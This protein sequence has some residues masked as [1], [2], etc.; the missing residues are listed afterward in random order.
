MGLSCLKPWTGLII[1]PYD[2]AS[3]D[4]AI[5]IFADVI[6]VEATQQD[7]EEHTQ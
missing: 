1:F 4:D 7:V 6:V 2:L 3:L 5:I